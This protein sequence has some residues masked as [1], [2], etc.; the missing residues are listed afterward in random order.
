MTTPIL[1]YTTQGSGDTVDKYEKF[2]M[3]PL[4]DLL[5]FQ[6]SSLMAFLAGTILLI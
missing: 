1:F 3:H 6:T 2:L 4:L 5:D